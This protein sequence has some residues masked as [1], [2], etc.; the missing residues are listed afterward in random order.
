MNLTPDFA[1]FA[2]NWRAGKNQTV[3]TSLVSDTETPISA[4][5]KLGQGKPHSFLLESIEGGAV[6]GRYSIIG[7]EPDLIWR[8]EGGKAAINRAALKNPNDFSP[9][10]RGPLDDLR[11]LLEEIRIDD[12]SQPQ[13]MAAGLFGYL[14]YEMVRYMERLPETNPGGVDVPEAILIRPTL[15]AICDQIENKFTLVTPVWFD[16]VQTAEAAYAAAQGRLKQALEDLGRAPPVLTQA[17][18]QKFLPEPSANMGEADYCAMAERAKDYIRAG[19]I[20]QVV[21][22]QRFSLPFTLPPFDLYRAVRRL[23]PSP[24]LFFFDLGAF[25]VVGSSPEI[26]VRVRDGKVT[27]RPIAG[28]RPRGL[29]NRSDSELAADLLADPKELAEHLMLLDLGRNDVGRVAKT[30]TVKVTARNTIEY[31]RHVMHIVSN[32]EGELDSKH[33]PLEALMGGFPAGTVSG[34]PK[35]RAMEIINELEPD[36]RG[37]YAGCIGYFGANGTMDTCIAIRTAVIKDGVMHVQAGAGIV[38]DSD[39][40][41]EHRECVAKA[42]GMIRAAQEALEETPK[43]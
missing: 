31:Y 39:P 26:L 22:S 11:A 7:R 12:P 4:M 15:L 1:S 35:I 8:C 2:R 29:G 30:G 10:P 33:T 36:R 25:S 14:G 19:D 42:R 9:S 32:V 27:I 41:S 3:W 38:Y 28:T 34:A 20:F 18:P 5:L 16:K 21:L 17:S 24:F 6:R 37:V 40:Q 43:S 23:D 13:P